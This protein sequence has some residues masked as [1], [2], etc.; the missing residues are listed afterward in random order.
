MKNILG[1]WTFEI[2]S[3]K[4]VIGF[5]DQPAAV[6]DGGDYWAETAGRPRHGGLWTFDVTDPSFRRRR[7]WQQEVLLRLSHTIAQRPTAAIPL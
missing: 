2:G 3:W 4:G 1:K 6:P 5:E 7:S